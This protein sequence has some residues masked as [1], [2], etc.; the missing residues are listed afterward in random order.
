MNDGLIKG[1]PGQIVL[2][3]S[4]VAGWEVS[5]DMTC[6][7]CQPDPPGSSCFWCSG[8]KKLRC[9]TYFP[10]QDMAKLPGFIADLINSH[11]ASCVR[12]PQTP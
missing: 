10:P 2:A 3:P 6:D 12:P 4:P 9:A 7:R 5:H 1:L 11:E 8:R